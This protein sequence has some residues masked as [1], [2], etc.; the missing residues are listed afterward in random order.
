MKRI[1]SL[2]LALTLVLGLV[3]AVVADE[4]PASDLLTLTTEPIT[5]RYATN[6]QDIELTKVLADQFMQ[7]YPNITVEVLEMD[8]ATYQDALTNM[9]STQNLPDVFWPDAVQEALLKDWLLNLTPYFEADPDAKLLNQALLDGSVIGG[10]QY[11]VPMQSAPYVMVVNKTIFDKYNVEMPSLTWT[12]EEYCEKM[13]EVSHPEDYYFGAGHSF[14]SGYFQTEWGWDGNSYTFSD[15]WMATEETVNDWVSRGLT[16][17]DTTEEER[18]TIYGDASATASSQGRVA[19][20]P[21]VMYTASTAGWLDGTMEAQNGCDLVFYP[22][23]QG[24]QLTFIQPASIAK[25]C[26][27]PNEAWELMKWMGWGKEATLLIQKYWDE[28]ETPACL[29][30][31]I[32][33]EEVWQDCID[34]AHPELKDFMA[35]IGDCVPYNGNYSPDG[36]NRR[37]NWNFVVAPEIQSGKRNLADEVKDCYKR[38]N[39]AV[40]R[41]FKKCPEFKDSGYVFTTATDLATATDADI[42]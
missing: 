36:N 24:K 37:I 23:P 21:I 41:Y 8:S 20:E 12:W 19:M 13:E 15:D 18:L 39:D 42:Q 40:A 22:M 2:L 35:N 16:D 3:P 17:Q 26:Q 11:S 14:N 25:S 5:L 31:M 7:Q 9:A 38:Y 4:A 28:Q 34:R 29:I 32:D 6:G 27:Y 10:R 30:P 33:D 1:V